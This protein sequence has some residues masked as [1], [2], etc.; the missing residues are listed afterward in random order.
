M[1]E[2]ASEDQRLASFTLARGLALLKDDAPPED[3]SKTRIRPIGIN[4]VF[5][6][7]LA[8]IALS[9]AGGLI[10]TKLDRL[11]LGFGTAGG[12]EAVIHSLQTIFNRQER[13]GK[14]FVLIQTDFENAFN[15]VLRQAIFD[16]V[17]E[18]CP[19]LLFLLN[20]RYTNLQAHFVSGETDVK[21]SSTA[22]VSQG[23]PLSPALFQL[24]MSCILK[25]VRE[26][27]PGVIFSF[28]DDN[29]IMCDSLPAAA[30]AFH[31][32]K[33]RSAKVGLKMN[34]TKCHLFW[35][36]GAQA[37]TEDDIIA[38]ESLSEL[39]FSDRGAHV[40][41]GS[42]GR[43][44]F[45]HE[46]VIQKFKEM[47][48]RVNDFKEIIAYS[49]TPAYRWK[50]DGF[51]AQK[52]LK[53][54]Q[55]CLTPLAT[56]TIRT[57][58]PNLTRSCAQDLDMAIAQCF[59]QLLTGD[60]KLAPPHPMLTWFQSS[61]HF[62]RNENEENYVRICYDRIF[63]RQ[64]GV[65]LHSTRNAVEP[66]YLGSLALTAPIIQCAMDKS[67]EGHCNAEEFIY[68]F[69]AIQENTEILYRQ[70]TK[71]DEDDSTFPIFRPTDPRRGIQRI[72]TKPAKKH[73]S[74]K[75]NQ[76]FDKT[77]TKYPQFKNLRARFKAAQNPMAGAWLQAS[78]KM[79]FTLLDDQ[80]VRDELCKLVGLN[81]SL[82]STC[83]MCK[84]TT[85]ILNDHGVSCGS[86]LGGNRLIGNV[87]ERAVGYG[88]Q[89]VHDVVE[90][91][92]KLEDH[93]GF[94]PIDQNQDAK[95]DGD[96]KTSFK[97]RATIIDVTFT[98]KVDADSGLVEAEERKRRE[99]GNNRC[100]N[101]ERFV[102]MAVD[103]MG[104][105]GK[106]MIKYFEVANEEYKR[107]SGDRTNLQMRYI[108][109]GIS[110][111][112][113]K[114]NGMFMQRIRTGIPKDKEREREQA[115]LQ[116]QNNNRGV[117]AESIPHG[118]MNGTD[119]SDLVPGVSGT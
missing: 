64:G 104:G 98:S 56:Y 108:R 96:F 94:E 32:I 10:A 74:D 97:G 70:Y 9:K 59:S 26:Q 16:A 68:D 18:H 117:I 15:S 22:G 37:P 69:E 7:L 113:C 29:S 42:V 100:R 57:A 88:L 85:D 63:L 44:D 34:L 105:W 80:F 111:A 23:C 27:F 67:F 2:Q 20:F 58:P 103:C 36:N 47:T 6:N 35:F 25:P 61:V 101:E 119:P 92:P 116:A 53:F 118:A 90:R 50:N 5:L 81:Q 8:R 102:V 76:A 1:G 45:L 21:I 49:Q 52:I 79:S 109:E 39:Q 95:K 12:A 86:R 30:A 11:D 77:C 48:A 4:E 84:K 54:I 13:E 99:Y 31:L 3:E 114:A 43:E 83:A 51:M 24:V 91:I 41:G 62:A 93:I 28:L 71:A 55:Y 40:L 75:T 72:L 112:V 46:S 38:R 66:A 17:S 78:T 110:L 87:V 19:E 115:R 33:E 60:P 14:T 107:V 73:R 106:E 89:K 65:G 82:P